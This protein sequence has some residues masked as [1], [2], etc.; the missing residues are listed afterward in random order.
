MQ[1]T[2]EISTDQLSD[3]FN[4]IDGLIIPSFEEAGPLVGIEAMAAGKIILSTKVGAMMERLDQTPNQFWFDIN[5][6]D[7]LLKEVSIIEN[8]SQDQILNIREQVRNRYIDYYSEKKIA[9]NYVSLFDEA[10]QNLKN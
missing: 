9:N 6:Q 5:N 8:K 7:S 1:Y 2:G 4:K 10:F 3:F